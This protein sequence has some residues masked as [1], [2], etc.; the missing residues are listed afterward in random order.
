MPNRPATAVSAILALSALLSVAC[1]KN[2]KLKVTEVAPVTT[3]GGN[4]STGNE[5]AR[6]ALGGVRGKNAD[7]VKSA[8]EAMLA[9]VQGSANE[10]RN[11][12]WIAAFLESPDRVK[13]MSDA[14]GAL[15]PDEFANVVP[16]FFACGSTSDE[17]CSQVRQLS[18]SVVDLDPKMA[19]AIMQVVARGGDVAQVKTITR[20]IGTLKLS[21]RTNQGALSQA[22]GSAQSKEELT[23]LLEI[24]SGNESLTIQ[25][26]KEREQSLVAIS[27]LSASERV[28]ALDKLIALEGRS[29]APRLS[30]PL[31]ASNFGTSWSDARAGFRHHFT[32]GPAALTCM[33][34]RLPCGTHRF[35]RGSC[36]VARCRCWNSC[37]HV[38][39]FRWFQRNDCYSERHDSRGQQGS[40]AGPAPCRPYGH[41]RGTFFIDSV[42]VGPR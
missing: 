14:L 18:E 10:S 5:K 41:H 3:T 40:H 38:S 19:R 9:S 27:K 1:G 26:I 6:K 22:V 28:E 13:R 37:S 23:R 2:S 20:L 21:P 15:T 30:T 31:P 8:Y 32:A 34:G 17:K 25:Q 7:R 42:F 11:A 24:L 12:D 16:A 39:C 36:D 4:G 35:A 33:R 29:P